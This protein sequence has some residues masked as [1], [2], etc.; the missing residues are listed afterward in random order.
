[1][2]RNLI[3]CG[4]FLGAIGLGACELKVINPNNPSQVQ[5]KTTPTDLDNFLGSLYRRWHSGLYGTTGNVWGMAN[6]A[7]FENY[8]TL[9]NNCQNQRYTIPDAPANN[10]QVG[11]SCNG[12]QNFVYFRLAETA[13]G[14]SD[15]LRRMDDGLTFGSP[16]QDARNRAF[17][18]FI[19]GISLGYVA[20]VYDSAAIITPG[21]PITPQGTAEP[22]ELAKYKDVFAEAMLALGNAITAA[23]AAQTATGGANFPLPPGWMFTSQPATVTATEFIKIVRSYRARIR[24]GVVR[25]PNAAACAAGGSQNVC[26]DELTADNV[27]WAA[28][29]D[30]A[31]N[32]LTQDLRITT[33]TVTGPNMSWTN[34]WYSYTTWHQMTPF[35]VGQADSSGAYAAWIATPIAGRG[36]GVFIMATPDQRWPQGTTR[37]TQRADF[38]LAGTT[39]NAADPGCSNANQVCKRFFRNRD[40]S[41]PVSS[42]W[43]VSQYDHTR[44]YSWKTSGSGGTGQNGPFPFFLKAELDML[45]AE[46][47]FRL[48]DLAGAMALVNITRTAC[49]F[50]AVPAGC[51]ARPAGNGLT[52][53]PGGGLPALVAADNTT[54]VPGGNACVPKRPVNAINA[55]GGTVIC[56][57]LFDALKWEKRME[58][59]YSHFAPWFFDER[60]WGDLAI[61]TAVDWAPPYEDLQTRFRIGLQ[62]YSTG[63]PVPYHRA[64]QSGYGW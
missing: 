5:V 54:P 31:Q 43:G 15:V 33:S 47:L 3:R 52:G 13:R 1:M 36:P 37:A 51:T 9:A 29:R 45:Q 22:G 4:A 32:G 42:G 61:N 46:A 64:A 56:G 57:T 2:I 17:A 6:I 28:V 53:E 49:G 63:G 12:E 23:T 39:G 16:A 62:I 24:A 50:G 27:D 40:V 41:D 8:S 55:G 25:Y 11:N 48:G 44:F 34:Q 58:E 7:S 19:R 20:M 21:D 60:R 14:A 10:N 38:T 18:E 59:A 35:I 26:A 30:D